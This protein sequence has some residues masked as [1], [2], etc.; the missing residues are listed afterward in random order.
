[1]RINIRKLFNN[2]ASILGA[3]FFL[4]IIAPLAFA[5]RAYEDPSIK[6]HGQ[7]SINTDFAFSFMS[8]GP[9]RIRSS[10]TDA[11]AGSRITL[12]CWDNK[13]IMKSKLNGT[14]HYKE[15]EKEDSVSHYL[16]LTATSPYF[17]NVTEALEEFIDKLDTKFSIEIE[18]S[19]TAI[20][21]T[22]IYPINR[23]NLFRDEDDKKTLIRSIQYLDY[24]P[25][26]EPFLQPKRLK[27]KNEIS[28]ESGTITIDKVELNSGLPNFLFELPNQ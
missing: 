3:A 6:I 17:F 9:K 22:E 13:L 2:A 16:D 21:D 8:T 14:I 18:I 5:Q 23:I 19:E 1:M 12:Y 27:F 7:I 11:S 4:Q 25:E 26:L 10:L 24:M 28:G 15:I 20:I